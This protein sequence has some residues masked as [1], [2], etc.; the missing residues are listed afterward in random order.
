M[1]DWSFYQGTSNGVEVRHIRDIASLSYGEESEPATYLPLTTCTKLLSCLTFSL[2]LPYSSPEAPR[3]GQ[4]YCTT[5]ESLSVWL[6]DKKHSIEDHIFEC[7]LRFINDRVIWGPASCHDNTIS[8]GEAISMADSRFKMSFTKKGKTVEG[9]T[10]SISKVWA[11]LNGGKYEY[12]A[13]VPLRTHSCASQESASTPRISGNVRC[14]RKLTAGLQMALSR[15]YIDGDGPFREVRRPIDSGAALHLEAAPA[16]SEG[17]R[18]RRTPVL[19]RMPPT[20]NKVGGPAG[21]ASN[22]I[23]IRGCKLGQPRARLVS[24]GSHKDTK[25]RR[26]TRTDDTR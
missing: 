14:R 4:N 23:K 9:H 2:W 12:V 3:Q 24:G 11:I 1:I 17:R 5:N 6:D 16:R 20:P 10:R 22:K 13:K 19:R 7:T 26:R 18:R 25:K 21:A 8:L 15:D